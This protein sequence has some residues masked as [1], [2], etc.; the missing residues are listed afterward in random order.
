MRRPHLDIPLAMIDIFVPDAVG[1]ATQ[2]LRV[3]AAD[4]GSESNCK[5]R[6]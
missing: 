5:A 2:H 1:S 4:F 6:R 3:P